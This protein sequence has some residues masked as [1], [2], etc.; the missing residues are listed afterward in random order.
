MINWK[1]KSVRLLLEQHGSDDPISLIKEIT[2]ELVIDAL[3]D[4]WSGPPYNPI[5]LAT[6]IG[7]DVYPNE[8]IADAR[9]IPVR[10]DELLIE[11]N[12]FQR[13]SRANFSISHEIGHTLFPDCSEKIR[14]REEE[15]DDENWELEFLCNVAASEILLP[16]AVFANEANNVELKMDSLL[17]ISNKYGASLEAVFLRFCEVVERPCAISICTFLDDETL[18]I[19]YFKPSSSF[20]HRLSSKTVIPSNSVAYQCINSGT[21]SYGQE[22]WESFAGEQHMIYAIGLPPIKR[23]KKQRVGIF[24]VPQVHIPNTLPPIYTVM[25]DAREPRGDGVKIIFQTV[26]TYGALGSG[27]GKS[28]STKWP[29]SKKTIQDWKQNRSRLPLGESK[30]TKLEE[31]IFVLQSVVQKGIRSKYGETL[32]SYKSLR[33]ALIELASEALRLDASVHMPQVGAGQAK[34]DWNIIEGMIHDELKL[35]GIEVTVYLFGYR[36]TSKKKNQSNLTLFDEDSL[37]E[38]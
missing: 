29:K 33:I 4:G 30:L 15:I 17:A 10:K 25:G 12:P 27:F 13:G 20:T 16:Y 2:R 24:M 38:K 28:M 14:N 18:A 11:Y 9:I 3:Q 36:K 19:D 35:K 5:E 37:H 1:S 31:D 8:S 34:G 22:N 6:K 26:N 21:T 23:H 7:I 32:L